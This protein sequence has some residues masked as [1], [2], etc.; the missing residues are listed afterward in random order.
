M[1]VMQTR[2]NAELDR[3]IEKRAAC[4]DPEA[5]PRCPEPAPRY[6]GE[7]GVSYELMFWNSR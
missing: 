1:D 4:G 5:L 7:G 3:L 2:V 6:Q